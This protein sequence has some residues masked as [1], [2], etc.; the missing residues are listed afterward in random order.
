MRTAILIF[1]FLTSLHN[2]WAQNSEVGIHVGAMNYSGDLSPARI[3]TANTQ[4]GGGVMYRL[5]LGD[6]ISFRSSVLLG[7]LTG[8][9]STRTEDILGVQRNH[10]F[11]TTIAEVSVVFEYY[12]LSRSVLGSPRIVSPYVF[13]GI[14]T[15]LRTGDQEPLVETSKL[16]PVMPVG[17][18]IRF[19][20]NNGLRIGLEG[21]F[22]KTFYDYLD[23]ISAENFREKTYRVGDQHNTDYYYYAG[24]SITYIISKLFCVDSPRNREPAY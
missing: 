11:K 6:A 20:V 23:G 19:R 15:M 22:R 9:D 18:G 5:K 3:E 1:L 24:L 2:L 4:V 21:G 10:S 13:A 8:S 16:Q 7:E 14:G 17:I 12:L